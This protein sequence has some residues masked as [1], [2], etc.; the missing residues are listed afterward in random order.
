MLRNTIKDLLAFLLYR[1]GLLSCLIRQ[2]FR[3]RALVLTYHRVLPRSQRRNTFS[4]DAI[5]VDPNV[6]ERHIA[7]LNRHFS[8]IDLMEF[9]SRLA[10]RD[11]SGQAQCLI[12]FDDA[13]Q[14][15]YTH[16]FG[17]LKRWDTPA[18]IFV[19][20]DYIGSGAL[21]WQERMGHLVNE[22][23]RQCGDAAQGILGKYDWSHIPAMTEERRVEEIKSA[24][25]MIKTKGYDEIEQIMADLEN[26]LAGPLT[27]FGPDRYLSVDQMQEMIKHRIDF[28]SHGCTHRMFI[29]LDKSEL[30]GELSNSSRW[31]ACSLGCKPIA[32]AYPNG[33]HNT[34][35][36]QQTASA[37]YKLAFT[38]IG[39]H[40]EPDS[41]PFTLRR[42]NINDNAAGNEA[43][44]L[45]TLLLSS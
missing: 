18:V 40:V 20:T 27:D 34:D 42:I 24:I 31:L 22:I 11:F 29:R 17:I 28:Q 16:A 3:N 1:S 7:V 33:D 23:C 9:T 38:T 26:A 36:Q 15:N 30:E 8:C 32:L 19:P 39:G 41:D 4:H 25:R 5:I 14:D 13:W 10:Q 6:F 37:G 44:L 35:I 2:K 43:R 12:T 21:F 45:L